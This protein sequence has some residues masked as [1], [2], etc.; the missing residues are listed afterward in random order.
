[1]HS[2]CIYTFIV[3]AVLTTVHTMSPFHFF[4]DQSPGQG[5]NIGQS[6]RWNLC[7]GRNGLLKRKDIREVKKFN[8]GILNFFLKFLTSAYV[9]GQIQEHYCIDQLLKLKK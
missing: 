8:V 9:P 7:D 3:L 1:M 4:A 6:R 5:T 2:Q